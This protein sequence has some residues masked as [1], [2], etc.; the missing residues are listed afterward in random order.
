VIVAGRRVPDERNIA[1]FASAAVTEN[2]PS[3]PAGVLPG[4]RFV[5][6]SA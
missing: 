2:D 6:G 1:S 5:A 3:I 4:L